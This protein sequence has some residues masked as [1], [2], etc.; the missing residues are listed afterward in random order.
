MPTESELRALLQGGDGGG[1]RLDAERI[2][3]L[4]RARR[5]PKR[6][7]AGALTGLAAAAIVV[8]ATV[9]LGASTTMS[10]SDG[11]GS[12]AAPDEAPESAARDT[13]AGALSVAAVPCGASL[14]AAESPVLTLT[15]TPVATEP[16]TLVLGTGLA[17]APDAVPATDSELHL[18]QLLLVR[19][20]TVAGFATPELPHASLDVPAGSDEVPVT[21]ALSACPVDG[22]EAGADA[23]LPSGVYELVAAGGLSALDG[24]SWRD[25]DGVVGELTIR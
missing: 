12:A 17:I 25:V 11:A 10:G 6:I 15:L 2:I 5:R 23:T 4:A 24:T 22:A 16:G 13:G 8:P 1:D 9:G 18:T 21:L 20:G 14:K 19:E 3:R 7:A